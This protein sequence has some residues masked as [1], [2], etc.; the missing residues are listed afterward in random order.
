MLEITVSVFGASVAVKFRFT[1]VTFREGAADTVTK[2][3]SGFNKPVPLTVIVGVR[4]VEPVFG[5]AVMVTIPS[6]EPDSG[7]IVRPDEGL[8]LTLQSVLDLIANE[9]L[10]PEDEKSIDFFDRLKVKGIS[11]VVLRHPLLIRPNIITDTITFVVFEYAGWLISLFILSIV[12]IVLNV[13][14]GK[15]QH[16]FH[17]RFG[18]SDE[19]LS[20]IQIRC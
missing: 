17:C 6:F 7:E 14:Q 12:I 3:V 18:Y 19:P 16:L 11:L 10:P 13:Y 4:E 15:A 5:S 1:G 9:S 2:M 20:R 8:L